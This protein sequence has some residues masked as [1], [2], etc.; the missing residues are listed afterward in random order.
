[1]SGILKGNILGTGQLENLIFNAINS[2]G[3]ADGNINTPIDPCQAQRQFAQRLANAIAEGVAKGAQQYLSE[4]VKTINEQTLPNTDG[5]VPAHIHP[6]T[7]QY[8][9]QAP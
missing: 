7:P 6:N 9:L 5:V 3:C 8:N 1:M 2:A 4:A